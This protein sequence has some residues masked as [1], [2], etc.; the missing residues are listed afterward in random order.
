MCWAPKRANTSAFQFCGF[1]I[2]K[3]QVFHGSNRNTIQVRQMV[4]PAM[5][6][7]LRPL[8]SLSRNLA[9]IN[10][11]P[12]LSNARVLWSGDN[13]GQVCRDVCCRN[14]SNTRL[15]EFHGQHC[16]SAQT[17]TIQTE[18]VRGTNLL[19]TLHLPITPTNEISLR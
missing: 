8:N 16:I 12:T 11:D 10:Y 1:Q 14:G 5:V 19:R 15:H 3:I 17:R 13:E 18:I 9:R 6:G 7:Y 2:E 4:H